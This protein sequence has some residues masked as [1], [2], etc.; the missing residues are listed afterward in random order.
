MGNGRNTS[1]WEDSWA[2][3]IPLRD[4]FPRLFS[5]SLQ[6]VASVADLWNANGMEGWNLCWRRR[7]FEWEKVLL[8][9]LLAIINLFRPSEDEDEWRWKAEEEG[10]FTVKS[11]YGLMSTKLLMRRDLGE[12]QIFSFKAIWKSPAPSKVAGL[13]WLV[14]LDRVPTREN[15]FRRKIIQGEEDQCCVFCG[16]HTESVQHLFVYCGFVLQIWEQV[17]VWLRLNFSLP[18]SISSMLNLLG[19]T[20]GS[21]HSRKGMVM[22]W[23]AVIWGIWRH[24]NKIIFDNG[25]KDSAKL[26]EDIKLMAWKWWISRGTQSP[27]LLYEWISEP[28]ICLS[29]R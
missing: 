23:S 27:C 20:S 13:A 19:T 10:V 21:K 17:F 8:N 29:M 11:T 15:L 3:D 26:L 6:K 28:V 24:R 7:L 25:V 18:H 16:E 12:D 14:L 5:I 22:I 4:S 9:D 2:G 1:F